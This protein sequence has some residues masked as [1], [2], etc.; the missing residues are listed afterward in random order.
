MATNK[1]KKDDVNEEATEANNSFFSSLSLFLSFFNT[2]ALF[3]PRAFASTGF[4]LVRTTGV[5]SPQAAYIRSMLQN[6]REKKRHN[7]VTITSL[8][9]DMLTPFCWRGKNETWQTLKETRHSSFINH[10]GETITEEWCTFLSCCL[11]RDVDFRV[12]FSVCCFDTR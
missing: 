9:R 8:F 5:L 3:F 12:F 4:F 7:V 1:R 11:L 10:Q 6:E 2:T